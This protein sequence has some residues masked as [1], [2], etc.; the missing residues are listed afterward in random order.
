ML[1]FGTLHYGLVKQKQSYLAKIDSFERKTSFYI[2]HS[3]KQLNFAEV[4]L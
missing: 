1:I 3:F 2:T 4:A